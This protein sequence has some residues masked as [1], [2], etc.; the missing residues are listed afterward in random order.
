[1]KKYSKRFID[2]RN[3]L[4]ISYQRKCKELELQYQQDLGDLQKR[5]LELENEIEGLKKLVRKVREKEDRKYK[6]EYKESII[7]NRK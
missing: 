5:L 6:K 1:M 4:M 3:E 2:D 7:N